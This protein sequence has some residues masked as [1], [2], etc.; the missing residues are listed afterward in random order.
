MWLNFW[1]IVFWF[2]LF[3]FF[4]NSLNFL[5]LLL[6]SELIW[7]LLYVITISSGLWNDD[8]NLFSLSFFLLGLAGLE[9]SFCLLLIIL[10]KN[11]NLSLNFSKNEKLLIESEKLEVLRNYTIL[12]SNRHSI[13]D[14]RPRE[15]QPHLKRY[16]KLTLNKHGNRS[17]MSNKEF[18]F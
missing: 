13:L 10:F 5:N 18:I 7:I 12:R 6:F 2:S 16:Y 15:I 4:I 1:I 11:S 8:L 3:I 9:F 17:F 14:N